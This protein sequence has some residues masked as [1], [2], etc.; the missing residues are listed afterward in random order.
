MQNII[1]FWKKISLKKKMVFVIL[2]HI[3]EQIIFATGKNYSSYY[4]YFTTYFRIFMP[5]VT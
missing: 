4:L 2:V 1:T 3:F 5:D